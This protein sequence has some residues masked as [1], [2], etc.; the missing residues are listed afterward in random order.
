MVKE[1]ELDPLAE[2]WIFLDASRTVHSSLP[3]QHPE[4][5]PRDFWRARFQFKLP[6][7]TVEYSVTV[8]ASLARYYL[9]RGRAVGL[10]TAGPALQI[11]PSDRGGRQLSKVLEG[12]ALLRAEFHP[13]AS[14]VD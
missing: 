7:S 12:L 2:V 1:F 4:F 5:D 3:Y 8:A 9:Q 13:P 10:V 11:L 6:P 14:G